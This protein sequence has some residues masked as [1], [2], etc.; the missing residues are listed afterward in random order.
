[1]ETVIPFTESHL[2]QNILHA[3]KNL[4][5]IKHILCG[6]WG[7]GD[8][9]GKNGCLVEYHSSSFWLHFHIHKEF[10]SLGE[11]RGLVPL[12]LCLCLSLEYCVRKWRERRS[13][14]ERGD[15]VSIFPHPRKSKL[16]SCNHFSERN[17]CE[18]LSTK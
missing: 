14:R 15:P 9:E 13:P 11:I 6:H 10:W 3:G 17:S 12:R 1:M 2:P 18:D 4:T 16:L 8:S 5:H 7:G